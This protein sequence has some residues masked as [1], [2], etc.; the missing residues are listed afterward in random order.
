MIDALAKG[1]ARPPLEIV[2]GLPLAFGD[3]RLSDRFWAKCIPEP[4]SGC[5]IWFGATTDQGYG[6]IWNEER[7]EYAHRATFRIATG[8]APPS[9]KVARG[10]VV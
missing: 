2:R 7:D 10:A 8:V 9:G 1:A 6:K 3:P 4:N 5:W